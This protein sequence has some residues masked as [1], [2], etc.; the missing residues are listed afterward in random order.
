MD[1]AFVLRTLVEKSVERKKKVYV[2][3]LD[4]EKAYDRV[5]RR[6]LWRVLRVYGIR[7]S[8]LR[9]VKAFYR[10]SRMC[11]RVGRGESGMF[12]VERGLRQGCVMSPWLFN[13]FMDSV[14]RGMER[15]G[16]GVIL[17]DEGVRWEVNMILFADDT[18]LVAKNEESLR[19]LVGEF[20]RECEEK[21]L[22]IN[23]RKSKV[24]VCGVGR[25]G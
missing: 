7:G 18:A 3:F 2:C 16:K 21:G 19:E 24:M 1:Q 4:L 9:G 12:E 6:E 15:E 11:V 20:E 22:K 14:C 17:E 8:L 25:E 5:R 13:V 23:P 10:G